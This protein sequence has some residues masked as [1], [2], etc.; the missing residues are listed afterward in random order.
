[1]RYS[2]KLRAFTILELL[3][4]IAIITILAALLLPALSRGTAKAK[5]I[6]CMNSL[7][8][9]GLAF[10]MF[11]QDHNSAFP[12]AST[13]PQISSNSSPKNIQW[14]NTQ[15]YFGYRPFQIV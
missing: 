14:F 9:I 15:F 11:A 6:Q 13:A 2:A 8:Q 1:M 7:H 10:H 5:R 3:C 12:I 4:V